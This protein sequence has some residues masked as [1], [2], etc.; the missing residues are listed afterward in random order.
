MS[1][2]LPAA[3]NL[4][5]HVALVTGAGRGIGAATVAALARAGAEVWG[6]SRNAAELE[7]LA[8]GL[9][10]EDPAVRVHVRVLDVGDE[11][12]VSA[13]FGELD[14][15]RKAPSILVNNAGNFLRADVVDWSP[16]ISRRLFETHVIAPQLWA[17]EFF[18]RRAS[19]RADPTLSASTPDDACIV[20]ISSLGGLPH[21]DKFPGMSSYVAAKFAV[22]GLTEAWAVE[23]RPLGVRVNAVAPGA[24]RTRML[25][26]A[27]PFLK[28]DTGPEAVA[29]VIRGLCEARVASLTGSVIPLYTNAG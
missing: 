6:V 3:R 19:R 13:L 1:T 15:S 20:N 22:Y 5:G 4:E 10:A 11:A 24:V 23:G 8:N 21:T 2:K 18:R 7:A 25:S 26:E 14:V 9:R 12:G 16:E 27:A 28:T 29:E 17:R